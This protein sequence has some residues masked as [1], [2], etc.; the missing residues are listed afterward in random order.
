MT[1]RVAANK[2]ITKVSF[3]LWI[4]NFS[5][6]ISILLETSLSRKGRQTNFSFPLNTFRERKRER[7][8]ISSEEKFFE[9]QPPNFFLNPRLK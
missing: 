5:A 6:L 1:L 2:D 7:N 8:K 3:Q 4:L 9:Q